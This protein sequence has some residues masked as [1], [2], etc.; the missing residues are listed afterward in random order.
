M[1]HKLE[2]VNKIKL[3]L[4]VSRMNHKFW[5]DKRS[6]ASYRMTRNDLFYFLFIFILLAQG[7]QRKHSHN[8][9]KVKVFNF[10][11]HSKIKIEIF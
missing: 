1:S 3:Y 4:Q 11:G 8:L 5:K 10:F 6:A 7:L 2:N 9:F